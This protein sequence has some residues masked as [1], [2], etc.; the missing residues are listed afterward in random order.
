MAQAKAPPRESTPPQG[1]PVALCP[2]CTT[3]SML[4]ESRPELVEHLLSAGREMLLAVRAIIDARL[5]ESVP[6]G[7]LQR[8]HID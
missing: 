3:V 7:K 8:L 2:I 6:A 5:E 1:C 4:G